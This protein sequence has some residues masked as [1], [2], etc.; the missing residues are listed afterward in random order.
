MQNLI[1]GFLLYKYG[2]S[3]I[4]TLFQLTLG[5]IFFCLYGFYKLFQITV[6]AFRD[7]PFEMF[8]ILSFIGGLIFAV[9]HLQLRFSNKTNNSRH[10]RVNS[11]MISS[12][13]TNRR[14]Y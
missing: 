5:L 8:L 7:S 12:L 11:R 14:G 13:E 2:R 6:L 9:H 1:L 3:F 10:G 4:T